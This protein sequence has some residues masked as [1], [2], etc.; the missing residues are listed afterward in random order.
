MNP[1]IL[2]FKKITPL[3]L[4]VFALGCVGLLPRAQ[5]VSPPPDGGYPGGNTAEGNLALLSL[6]TGIYNNAVGIYSLL[7]LTTGNFNTADGAGALLS[8]TADENTATGAGALFDSTTGESNTATGFTALF[9][10]NT[11]GGNTATGADALF[12]NTAGALNTA[13]GGAALASNI[14]G[15]G[16]TA[17][18]IFALQDNTIGNTNTALGG[19]ALQNNTTGNN[20]IALGVSAGSA[21]TTG[22]N[23]IDIGNS[24]V[25]AEANTIRIGD[26]AI[27]TATYIAGAFGVVD[28]AS[29]PLRI[30]PDG[31]L[32]TAVSSARF[33]KDIKPMDKASES[34]LALK[35]VTFHYKNDAKGI[36][37][38]GLVAEEVAK[39]NPELVVL[40]HDGKP[41]TVRYEEVNAM[42]LNEFLKEHRKNEEQG[43]TI[44][45]LE[46]T[47]AKHEANCAKREATIAELKSG[48]EALTATVKE[49]ASQIQKVSTQLELSKAVP[50]TALNNH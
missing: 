5:A 12:S 19:G 17:D 31:H 15:I 43:A 25:A 29:I 26:S 4:I 9:S 1:L 11:G 49:Q 34:I 37:Q 47:V 45:E 27:H 14:A 13:T 6:T 10:N 35:P 39:V 24:G 44:A 41:Y 46:S 16:N 20:N 3:C 38:F 48:M 7:S 21:L 18:G 2:Q 28:A 8:N 50:R 36:P 22:D 40:D 30:A 23:N 33:K 32:A 42:L